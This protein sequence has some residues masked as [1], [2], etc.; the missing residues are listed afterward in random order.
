MTPVILSNGSEL[1]FSFEDGLLISDRSDLIS[2]IIAFMS[3]SGCTSTVVLI[4]SGPEYKA[5]GTL[6]IDQGHL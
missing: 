4:D 3:K 6:V 2:N 1:L 5:S